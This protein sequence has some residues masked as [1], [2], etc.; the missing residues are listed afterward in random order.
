MAK[1]ALK[2]LFVLVR[3]TETGL[4]AFAATDAIG[5]AFVFAMAFKL[6]AFPDEHFYANG[7][8]CNGNNDDG[9]EKEGPEHTLFGDGLWVIGLLN[10]FGFNCLF[11]FVESSIC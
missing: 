11:N 4:A 3:T 9:D 1:K 7:G 5:C 10:C 8:K 2:S 6:P